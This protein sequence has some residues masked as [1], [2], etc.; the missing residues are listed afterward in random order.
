MR[1]EQQRGEGRGERGD[2]RGE[3]G[4][5]Q[6]ASSFLVHMSYIL[7]LLLATCLCLPT[8]C[9]TQILCEE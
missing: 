3:T 4:R 8:S 7:L 5:V 2:A 6:T 9:S 1:G